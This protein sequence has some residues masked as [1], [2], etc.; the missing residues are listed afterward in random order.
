MCKHCNTIF[1]FDIKDIRKQ[2]V[3]TV[4]RIGYSIYIDTIFGESITCPV[5]GT[6]ELISPYGEL[7]NSRKLTS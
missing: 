3:E 2:N 5:C 6:V 1:D 4:N 7:K